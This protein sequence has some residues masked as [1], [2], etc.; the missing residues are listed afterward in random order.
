MPP[1][2]SARALHDLLKEVVDSP[3][4]TPY[5]AWVKVF[6][7]AVE[8]SDFARRH[9]EVMGLLQASISDLRV[10]TDRERERYEVYLP[11]WWVAIV[12]PRTDWAVD[13]KVI[14][15][16][17]LHMLDSLADSVERATNWTGA[18]A[19]VG[20]MSALRTA[21]EQAQFGLDR[22]A[23]DLPATIRNQ[24][25]ADLDHV[26]WLLDN[27]AAFGEARAIQAARQMTGRMTEAA[28]CR[29]KWGKKILAVIAGVALVTGSVSAATEDVRDTAT[30]VRETVE[31]LTGQ[32][33]DT[34][35]TD[36]QP[37]AEAC[38]PKAIEKK[39]NAK[40]IEAAPSKT[41]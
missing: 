36:I 30:S 8:S 15:G 29:P 32:D 41:E 14:D 22:T 25:Q 21:I 10:L 16:P 24:I 13:V 1:R 17:S 9:A 5:H 27:V 35:A 31:I 3:E 4:Q 20:N 6:G 37:F 18:S 34:A 19:A 40:A 11:N 39:G 26:M 7:C 23:S 38:E 33:R 28:V 12:L 2:S